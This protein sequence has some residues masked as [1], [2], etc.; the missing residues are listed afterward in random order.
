VDD[1]GTPLTSPS[2]SF[3]T[4][5]SSGMGCAIRTDRTVHCWLGPLAPTSGSF[6]R[7][8]TGVTHSCA[9]GDDASVTCWGSNAFGEGSPPTGQL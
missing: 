2:G 5:A 6:A 3:S 4:L 7:V 8:A 9:L 1:S